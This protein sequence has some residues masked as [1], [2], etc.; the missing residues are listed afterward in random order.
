M[1]TTYNII[2]ADDPNHEKVFAEIRSGYKVIASIS[3]E[4]GPDQLQ[5]ELPGP[6]SDEKCILR[7]VPLADFLALLQAAAR[8][9]L[10]E[11]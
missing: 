8:K 5:V 11:S 10:G 2:I 1:D 9:L 3:Q 7:H 6:D 4:A